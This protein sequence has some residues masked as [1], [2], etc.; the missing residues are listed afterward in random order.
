MDNYKGVYH[1]FNI[2][3]IN[4]AKAI[5]LKKNDEIIVGNQRDS[6]YEVICDKFGGDVFRTPPSSER[7]EEH[8]VRTPKDIEAEDMQH[9]LYKKY[10]KLNKV[11]ASSVLKK[12]AAEQ[13]KLEQLKRRKQK[14]KKDDK[15]K[16]EKPPKEWDKDKAHFDF[17]TAF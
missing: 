8:A 16:E 14:P 10:G 4:G 17:I 13:F 6:I 7:D 15:D 3:Q 9:R 12:I 11:V 2:G 1:Y 5:P